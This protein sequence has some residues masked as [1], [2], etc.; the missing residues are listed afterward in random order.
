MRD[1]ESRVANLWLEPL[2]PRLLLATD[3]WGADEIALDRILVT[4]SDAAAL[5]NAI[6]N[7]VSSNAPVIS[8]I[9]FINSAVIGVRSGGRAAAV[10]DSVVEWSRRPGVRCA[11][12]DFRGQILST[13]PDD[14]DF[15]ELWGM[16]NTGQ[17]GGTPDADI[18]APEA[19]ETFTGTNTVVVASIDTGVDYNHEDLADNMWTNEGEIAGNGIDDDGNGV[20]DDVYGYNAVSNTGDPLDDNGHGTHTAGTFGAVGNNGIGVAGVVWDVQIMALKS[21][22]SNGSGYTSDVLECIEYMIDM[23]VNHGVNVVA[24]NSSWKVS[25]YD[26]ALYDAIAAGNAA[27]IIFVASADNSNSNNDKIPVYPASFDLPGIISVAATDSK[28]LKASYSNWGPRTVDLGAPAQEIYSTL[29]DHDYGW[30]SGTSA[31]TPFVTGAA[32][33]IRGVNPSL[34]IAE[35]K[36]IILS[37]VDP[38]PTLAGVTV[39][40]G[41]LNLAKIAQ[42]VGFQVES[43]EPGAGDTLG[44]PL[45]DFTI[46]F[47]S[48]FD[49]VTID[50]SDLS[51]AGLPATSMTLIDSDTVMFH[52]AGSPMTAQGPYTM[53]M[54]QGAVARWSDGLPLAAWNSSFWYDEVPLEVAATFPT[55]G[56]VVA[57]PWSTLQI[58]LNEPVDGSSVGLD[59]LI[60]SH[61]QVTGAKQVDATTIEYTLS[62]LTTYEQPNFTFELPHRALSDLYGNPSSAYTGS[63]TLDIDTAPFPTPLASVAPA[64][65]L[66]YQGEAV[67]SVGWAGDVDTFTFDLDAGQTVTLVAD[68]DALL[69]PQIELIDPSGSF[70]GVATASAA[71]MDAVLQTVA[72]SAAGTYVARITGAS[73]TS[74]RYSVQ[75]LLNSAVSLEVHDGADNGSMATAQDL[76]ASYVSLADGLVRRGAVIDQVGHLEV[77]VLQETE[78][79]N[80]GAANDLTDYFTQVGSRQ[81][82]ARAQ[83]EISVGQD[84]DWDYFRVMAGPGDRL[85]I[86]LRGVDSGNGTLVDPIVR[87]YDFF[88]KLLATNDDSHMLESY[89]AFSDCRYKG[90]YYIAVDS[91]GSHTGTYTLYTTLTTTRNRPPVGNEDWYRF[92]LNDGEYA[93]LSVGRLAAFGDVTVELRNA[94]DTLLTMGVQTAELTQAINGFRDATSDGTPATYYVKVVTASPYSLVETRGSDFDLE[95]NDEFTSAQYGSSVLGA[96]MPAAIGGTSVLDEFP[97]MDSNDTLLGIEPPDTHVAVGPAHVVEVVNSAIAIFNKDGSLAREPRGFTEFFDYDVAADDRY[98]FSPVVVYDELAE[99]WVVGVLS[100]D[101]AS[102]AESDLLYA[103]SDT[104]DPTGGWSEQHRIDLHDVSPNLFADYATVGYNADAHVFT[105]NMLGA[106]YSQ[107]NI[108][109]IAKDTVLDENVATFTRYFSQ[110]PNSSFAMAPA[111]MHG[112]LP[113]EPMWFVEEAGRAN[114]AAIRAVRMNNVLSVSPLFTDHVLAVNAY[115]DPPSAVQPGG[116]FNTNDSRILNAEW[117]DDRLVATHTVGSAGEATVRWYEI[118]TAGDTALLVQ[119]GNVDGGAGVH[120]Y[121]PAIAINTAGDI[122]LTFMQSSSTEYVSMYVVGQMAGSLPGEMSAPA[123]VAAGNQTY[124]GEHGGGSGG[125]AVDPQTDTFWAANEISF[126]SPVPDPLWSTWIGQFSASPEI[127]RDYVRVAVNAGDVLQ[128]RTYTPFDGALLIGNMLDPAMELY[129]PVGTLVAWDRSSAP[130]GVNV[131]LN[132][133]ATVSGEYCVRIAS[134]TDGLGGEYVVRID[135][136]TGADPAP[137]VLDVDPDDGQVIVQFPIYPDRYVLHFSEAVLATSW[138]QNALTINGDLAVNAEI[139]DGN[140]LAY[141]IHD[142]SESDMLYEVHLLAGA[143]TDLQ[144]NP[145]PEAYFS[146]TVDRSGPR[147]LATS[148]NGAPLPADRVL[149]EGP[150][151]FSAT[152]SELLLTRRDVRAGLISPGPSDLFLTELRSGTLVE[153]VAVDFDPDALTFTASF[154][155]LSGGEYQLLLVSGDGAFEDILGHDLDGEPTGASADGTPS[156]DGVMGGHYSVFFNVDRR[157]DPASPFVRLDPLGGLAAVSSNEDTLHVANDVDGFTLPVGDGEFLSAILQPEANVTMSVEVVGVTG[158]FT[159]A[160][161]GAAVILPVTHLPASGTYE[162]RVFGDGIT[163]YTLQIFRNA[164]LEQQDGD[165]YPGHELAID[166]SYLSLGSGRYAVVGVSHPDLDIVYSADMTA[167]PGWTLQGGA[168]AWEYGTPQAA[169][170]DPLFAYTGTRIIGYDLGLNWRDGKYPN[171]MPAQY[172]I[173]PAFDASAFETLQLCFRRWL[174]IDYS[175]ADHAKIEV[176]TDGSTWTTVWEHLGAAIMERGWSYQTYDLTSAA[177]G[178]SSVRLRWAMGP[179]DASSNFYG[180]NIDD[181]VV[182]ENGGPDVDLYQLDLN[183]KAGETIEVA[184]AGRNWVDFSGQTLELLDTDGTTVL[185]TATA[186]SMGVDISNY[187]LGIHNFVV[188]A[189]GVYTLRLT[190]VV[191][192]EYT[193]LVTDGLTFDTEPNDKASDPAR[194]VDGTHGALG[195]IGTSSELYSSRTT[196]DAAYP[197]LPVEDFEEGLV[198][199]RGIA[200]SAGPI[201]NGAINE[202]FA[203]PDDI[204]PGLVIQEATAGHPPD[205]MVL[206]GAGR[207]GNASKVLGP[208]SSSGD[209]EILFPDGVRAV[210]FDISLDVSASVAITAYGMHGERLNAFNKTTSRQGAFFGLI[211]PTPIARIVLS[212]PYREMVDNVMFAAVVQPDRYTLTLES[213]Q[214]VLVTTQSPLD[215]P[216]LSPLNLLDPGLEI[217]SPSRALVAQDKNSAADGKNAWLLYTATESGTYGV[218]IYPELG[219]G[220]YVMSIFSGHLPET[221]F[222]A[223]GATDAARKTNLVMTFAGD[224]EIGAGDFVI[225]K[226]SDHSI[227]ETIP[228]DGPA[229]TIAEGIVTI[230]PSVLLE[231][232]TGYYVEIA[233]GALRDAWGMPYVGMSGPDA[234]SFQTAAITVVGRNLFYNNS[235]FDDQNPN[236]GASDDNAMATDKQAL[237]PDQLATL[238]NYSTYSRG[239]NGIMVDIAGLANPAGLSAADFE[240]RVG[241]TNDPASWPLLELNPG[242]ITVAVRSGSGSLGSDRVTILFPDGAAIQNKWLQVTVKAN[243]TTGLA[244]P[245][246]HYWGHAVGETGDV[247]GDTLVDSYDVAGVLANPHTAGD[248]AAITDP[249]DFNRDQL[250][251]AV[252]A[253]LAQTYATTPTTML[254]MLDLRTVD[255]PEITIS[256]SPGAVTEDGAANLVYTF[257]RSGSTAAAATIGFRVTGSAVVADDYTVSGATSYDAK[258]GTVTFAAASSTATVTIDPTADT[259]VELDETA[260]LSVLPG[261]NNKTGAPSQVSGTITSDDT[262]QVTQTVIQEGTNQRSIITYMKVTF[263]A[264]VAIAPGA[265]QIINRGTG[266]ALNFAVTTA[267][268]DGKMTATLAFL[269]GNS[270]YGRQTEFALN[271]GNYQ[272]TIDATKVTYLGLQLDGNRNGTAGDNFVFGAVAADKFFRYF[273]DMDGDRDVDATDYGRLGLTYRKIVGQT[274]FNKFFD[275]DGDGDVDA[276]DYGRFSLR[277]R[278]VLAF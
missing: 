249:Y 60:V 42:A 158:V 172:A 57:L 27:G 35:V 86:E 153:P 145:N 112:S 248:P 170:G 131:L 227:V 85:D 50:P 97:G 109:S 258:V 38:L 257:T 138:I 235:E 73:G 200:F 36:E 206:L 233:R 122:G 226:L 23:K 198:D 256:V 66:I 260:W 193:L 19:W 127:D 37:T 242:D 130:D 230:D 181:V 61:G 162:I 273:G 63:L 92:E 184:L 56:S 277:Y 43:S 5:E 192:G 12:P 185:A 3:T 213:G 83:G 135:S 14:A 240:F 106:S 21:M 100:A 223:N 254:R 9:P 99:R 78:P 194:S 196:F 152:L 53:T 252:D 95:D 263:N 224:I 267:V 178:Q 65:G 164:M 117:R 219:C 134:E 17:S 264:D 208:N 250:V 77:R 214:P 231:A 139:I 54:A 216:S 163:D 239:I 51:V 6:V 115:T 262:L 144:G 169:G 108:L 255:L 46:H 225:R 69:H 190:S 133:T 80:G 237:L 203:D 107:V 52:F 269:A 22:A 182:R 33:F 41:R 247:V 49:P 136:A 156:G 177:A 8:T 74:G 71:G 246:V 104:A 44:G 64:G 45:S 125:I 154:P 128:I 91:Y 155:T 217:Y 40:G 236:V 183:G 222:P 4:F 245:D 211:S 132:Y 201:R 179:T 265:F 94:T 228:V 160:A 168:G 15:S 187:D 39:S 221:L 29:P 149:D 274:G 59:D 180:W 96:I 102:A 98:Q 79:D 270:V 229:V 18:D 215:D 26:Q 146:F 241:N 176:S 70:I 62:G 195:V 20:I 16:H 238:A 34:T 140:S 207:I 124:G 147:V 90:Y 278:K 204:L 141:A 121:F 189:D 113:G 197:G 111:T 1:G 24:S 166:D 87:F 209:T 174:G 114:G 157:S 150:L 67:G 259:K 142:E 72:A 199:P 48:P 244:A 120:T 25:S 89:V 210:G 165:S 137:V 31:A 271:D 171:S 2:E 76:A 32:A 148:W 173:T 11:Q 84:K 268:V 118:D 232:D 110:R 202:C 7:S 151:T 10:W 47:S 13:I 105:F 143:V 159:A 188:P 276:T 82:T 266:Q 220:E 28:D 186:G 119:Q 68:A 243:A 93:S 58:V 261:T 212:S 191:Y 275:Y 30:M 126:D 129:D 88:G 205:E 55:E 251:D 161:P 167:N 272:L 101:S 218:N 123:L 175:V 75:L 103:V 253:A 81:Y 234:W 116:T